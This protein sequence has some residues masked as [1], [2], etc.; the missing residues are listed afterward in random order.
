M[1][2]KSAFSR[3]QPK[4]EV[5]VHPPVANPNKKREHNRQDENSDND[6]L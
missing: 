5:A 2:L 3:R 1:S 6:G 4:K